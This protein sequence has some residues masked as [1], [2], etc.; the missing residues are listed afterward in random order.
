MT[1]LPAGSGTFNPATGELTVTSTGSIG[2][3]RPF[4]SGGNLVVTGTGDAGVGY[5]LLSSTNLTLPLAQWATNA[6]GTFNGVGVS[7]NAIPISGTNL[8]F[9]LREP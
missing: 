1:I 8:F 9:L 7:S 2:L 4:I 5:T 3:N 6:T